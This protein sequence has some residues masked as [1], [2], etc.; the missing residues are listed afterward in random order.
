M[1]KFGV[2]K[3]VVSILVATVCWVLHVADLISK[4]YF[5]LSIIGRNGAVIYVIGCGLYQLHV[6]NLPKAQT[7]IRKRSSA[8]HGPP[9]HATVCNLRGTRSRGGRRL[10]FF[11]AL[12]G[13]QTRSSDENSVCSSVRLSHACI[14]TKLWEYLSRFL[15]HTKEHL[16]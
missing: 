16:A 14:V 3:A 10:I 15:Y 1:A 9:L 12:H 13:M 8:F 5:S 7:L 11:T 2:R 6:S 4:M